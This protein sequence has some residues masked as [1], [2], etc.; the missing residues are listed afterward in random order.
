MRHAAQKRA[1]LHEP[2]QLP[3]G[4]QESTGGTCGVEDDRKQLPPEEVLGAPEGVAIFAEVG[5]RNR[6]VPPA[7]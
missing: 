6:L 1:Q 5:T 2:F 7:L 3:K 4:R